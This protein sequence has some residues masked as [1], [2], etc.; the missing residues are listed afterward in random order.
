MLEAVQKT[1]RSHNVNNT[2][3]YISRWRTAMVCFIHLEIESFSYSVCYTNSNL[4]SYITAV[5]CVWGEVVGWTHDWFHT[6]KHVQAVLSAIYR[7]IRSKYGHKKLSYRRDS[8]RYG[9]RSPQPRS[10][11]YL[12]PVHNLRPLNSPTHFLFIL[13]SV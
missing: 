13:I 2:Y 11:I 7:Y 12:S 6:Q 9:C 1:R 4:P 8:A 3:A 10:I 5:W